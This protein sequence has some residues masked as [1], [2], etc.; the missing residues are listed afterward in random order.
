MINVKSATVWK[1][2][3]HIP[4]ISEKLEKAG[5]LKNRVKQAI[6]AIKKKTKAVEQ[7][8]GG[9][10]TMPLS[11]ES[12][13][14]NLKRRGKYSPGYYRYFRDIIDRDVGKNN[15]DKILPNV[16]AGVREQIERLAKVKLNNR[17]KQDIRLHEH[18]EKLFPSN[19]TFSTNTTHNSPS[20]L[21]QEAR[22]YNQT[23][24]D[25]FRRNNI[26][27]KIR[28]LAEPRLPERYGVTEHQLINNNINK[29]ADASGRIR[30]RAYKRATR[31]INKSL[32][33]WVDYSKEYN[34]EEDFYARL[35]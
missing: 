18:I 35:Y 10:D 29:Y 6:G 26:L 30:S 20:V 23:G 3:A 14:S 21:I 2:Y 34:E 12:V 27:S 8:Y 17:N 9:A 16:G 19:S 33:Q 25:N 1:E 22:I 7:V 5:F 24:G 15:Q 13:G 11:T 31:N 4:T 28:T 32:K